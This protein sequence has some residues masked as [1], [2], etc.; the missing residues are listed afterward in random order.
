MFLTR[1]SLSNFKNHE[2]LSLGFSHKINCIIGNNG[3]GKT[4]LLDAIYYLCLT[5]SYFNSTDQQNILFGKDFFR[6]EGSFMKGEESFDLVYKLPVGKRKELLVNESLLPKLSDHVGGFPAI[7]ISPDDSVLINGGSEE[8]RR[9]LDNTI[10]QVNHQYLDS[11]IQYNKILAQRNASLKRFAESGRVDNTLLDSYDQQMV[12]LGNEIHQARKAAIVLLESLFQN[13]HR[14]VS[15]G[16]EVTGFRYQSPLNEQAFESLLK[17]NRNR[18]L[19]LQRTDTGVH[20]DDIEFRIGENRLKRF[21]SQGQQKSFIVSLKFSQYE[22]IRKNKNFA[23]VLLIDDIFDKLDTDRS[24]K[25]VELISENGFGQVFI[26]DTGDAHIREVLK[27]K[28]EIFS[29]IGF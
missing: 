19:V 12:P 1:I 27:G 21:G 18:D 28:E 9:F 22:Y 24:R 2:N 8:R 10:S 26:T 5:K 6:L 4:N 23:P 29:F 17:A 3:V 14:Q 20:K 11:L 7:I 16:R 15:Y 25:L 13:F